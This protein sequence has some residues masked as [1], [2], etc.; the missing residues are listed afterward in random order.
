C[1]I[2]VH[3]PVGTIVDT[4]DFKFDPT[5]VMGAPSDERRLR[6]IGDNGVL[7]LFSDTVRVETAGS[8]PS[9]KVVFDKLDEEIGKSK[10]QVVIATFASNISRIYMALHCAG[11]H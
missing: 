8:T 5:P 1:A 11:K 10:G 7:A 4:G 2:A 3:T 9:E 6:R